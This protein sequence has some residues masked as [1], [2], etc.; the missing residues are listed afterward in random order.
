[1]AGENFETICIQTKVYVDKFGG[2]DRV[3]VGVRFSLRG[4]VHNPS[5][6]MVKIFSKEKTDL[7]IPPDRVL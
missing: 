3:M 7:P 2:R 6:L 1:M 5:I 4:F